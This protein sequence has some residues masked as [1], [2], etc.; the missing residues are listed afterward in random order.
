MF[1]GCMV[2]E[3]SSYCGK[4]PKAIVLSTMHMSLAVN[5]EIFEMLDD[6]L[7][8]EELFSIL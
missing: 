3:V 2:V 4:K 8:K 6:G 7:V 1:A 5:G